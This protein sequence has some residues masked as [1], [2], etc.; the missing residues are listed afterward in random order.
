V[1]PAYVE[2]LFGQPAFQYSMTGKRAILVEGAEPAVKWEDEPITVCVWPLGRDGYLM[3]WNRD[4]NV[5]SYSLT[6]ASRRFRPKIRVG[7]EMRG[8]HVDLHL[9]HTRFSDL[10]NSPETWIGWV[11]N[12]RFG[13]VESHQFGNSGGYRTWYCGVSD[14]GYQKHFA[15]PVNGESGTDD[16]FGKLQAFRRHASV[17][18]VMVAGMGSPD[19]G[20]ESVGPDLD[21]VRLLVK[22]SL[23]DRY[24]ARQFERRLRKEER[25]GRESVT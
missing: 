2:Q 14:A 1:R 20:L 16:A 22:P 6:T 4:E 9:G 7:G 12:R 15:V 21:Q 23:R 11:G 13:Y 17:N 25:C 10:P 19:L 3:T 18:S 24:K 5:V 8:E